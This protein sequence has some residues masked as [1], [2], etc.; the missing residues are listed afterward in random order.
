MASIDITSKGTPGS[1]ADI[2][3]RG[4]SFEGVLVMVNGIT[5]RDPQTGHFS[6]DIPV[7]LESVERVEVLRGG[8]SAMYGSSAAGGIVNIVTRTDTD[9]TVN[10]KGGSFSSVDIMMSGG[11]EF[12]GG[13]CRLFGI[14][15]A[16]GR[17]S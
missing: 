3:M 5:V 6:L 4:S 16:F 2:S 17:I 12:P 11:C 8:G 14:S 7:R 13:G 9:T 10:V 15:G 1:Q